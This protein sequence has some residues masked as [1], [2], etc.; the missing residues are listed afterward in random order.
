MK[1]GATQLTK[2]RHP[3]ILIVQ[4]PLEESRE[5]LA[6]ATE[7]VFASLANILGNGENMPGS[8]VV[9]FKD[10]KLFD[11]EI[12]YGLLQIAEGLAFLHNDVK[13]LHHNICPETIIVNHQGAWKIFGFDFCVHNDRNDGQPFWPVTEYSQFVPH[14]AQPNLDYFAPEHVLTNTQST[15][16]DM[17]SLGMLIYAVYNDG[18]PV[19]KYNDDL[20]FYKKKVL[21]LKNIQS[22]PLINIPEGLRDLEKMML[23][24]TPELRPDAH[25][26]TKVIGKI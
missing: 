10:Y 12:K 15:A 17:F 22:K 25:Q 20:N 26:F 8:P 7:P 1:R 4:H 11:V 19:N 24:T 2:L 18:N 9:Q 13:L 14:V 5:S 16:S 23:H 3:Q 21:E 6:F